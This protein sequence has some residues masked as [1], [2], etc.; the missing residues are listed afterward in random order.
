M[1]CL[2]DCQ[3]R[4]G[5]S[6]NI[7]FVDAECYIVIQKNTDINAAHPSR[8]EC[9][10]VIQKNTDINAVQSSRSECYIIIQKN[11]DINAAH[12][13]RYHMEAILPRIAVTR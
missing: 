13:S 11:T 3:T 1:S 7:A 8:S 4:K 10:I 12:S 5:M 2:S 9:Y 6:T